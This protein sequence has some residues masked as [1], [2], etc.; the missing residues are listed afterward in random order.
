MVADVR[1]AEIDRNKK[2]MIKN[3]NHK[4]VSKI[5]KAEKKMPGIKK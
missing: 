4:E 3:I 2:G 5:E 1:A